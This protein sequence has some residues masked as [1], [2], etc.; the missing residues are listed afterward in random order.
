MTEAGRAL[1]KGDGMV[2][3]RRVLRILFAGKRLGQSCRRHLRNRRQADVFD[4]VRNVVFGQ[5]GVRACGACLRAVVARL[6]TGDQHVGVNIA[7]SGVP[8]GHLLA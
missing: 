5:T 8:V 6:D 2:A 1:A 7:R 3:W 4:Q